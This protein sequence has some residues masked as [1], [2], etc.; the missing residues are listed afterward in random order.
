[1]AVEP[2]FEA[3]FSSGR[4]LRMYFD[5]R[6]VQVQTYLWNDEAVGYV[7]EGGPQTW[8]MEALEL[9]YEL[10]LD[11]LAELETPWGKASE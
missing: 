6:A 4:R 11:R 9:F 10:I 7:P 5:G 1:M 2:T 8:T 3:E